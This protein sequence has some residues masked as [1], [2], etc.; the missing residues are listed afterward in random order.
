MLKWLH[1]G[2]ISNN[3]EI[4]WV[5]VTLGRSWLLVVTRGYS[6]L[7]VV[8]RGYSWL[9]VVTRGY[10]WSL[11][12]THSRSWVRLDPFICANN[13]LETEKNWIF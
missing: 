11:M 13:Y 7:L 2:V 8:T 12:A 6:S 5:D 3:T 1:N 9:L 10:S 4:F